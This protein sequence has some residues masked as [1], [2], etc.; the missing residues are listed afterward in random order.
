MYKQQTDPVMYSY[1]TN[2]AIFTFMPFQCTSST[3][4][5][6]NYKVTSS[7]SSIVA[8]SGVSQPILNP[9]TGMMEIQV[10]D[11]SVLATYNFYIYANL[12]LF[13][14]VTAYSNQVSITVEC[15]DEVLTS[16]NSQLVI[17]PYW[18]NIGT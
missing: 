5:V 7:S 1:V 14:S 11:P 16:S 15:G 6:T 10:L 9:S 3:C 4:V 8:V 12:E 2:P 18:R 17:T 13:P